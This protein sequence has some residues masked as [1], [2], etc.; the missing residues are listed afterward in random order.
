MFPENLDPSEISQ[1]GLHKTLISFGG[2][3]RRLLPGLHVVSEKIVWATGQLGLPIIGQTK[4]LNDA[5]L[6]L[7]NKI[8][9]LGLNIMI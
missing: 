8:T 5:D 4:Q 3:E 9:M 6:P 2:T 7:A 1:L